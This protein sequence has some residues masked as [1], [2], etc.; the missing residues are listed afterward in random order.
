MRRYTARQSTVRARGFTLLEILVAL[1]VLS[2]G[3][4]G[5][6]GMQST[7]LRFN[8]DAYMRSQATAL[9]YEMADRVRANAQALADDATAYDKG[10]GAE[11]TANADCRDETGC[12]PAAMAADD[13]FVWNER[14]SDILPL[15]RSEICRYT[16]AATLDCSVAAATLG[17][18]IRIRWDGNRDGVVDP[19]VPDPNET[20][21]VSFRP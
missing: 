2:I 1:V 3:L 20:I 5:L 13:L 4:I 21:V 15:G 10:W 14:V 8:T 9:A 12:T 7:S 17:H 19:E 18:V 6:A 16:D 11:G